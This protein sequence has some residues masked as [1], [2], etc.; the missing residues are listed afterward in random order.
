[1]TKLNPQQ[2]LIEELNKVSNNK[3]LIDLAVTLI[4]SNQDFINYN[5]GFVDV[6][7]N[8]KN[9]SIVEFDT[10]SN[11]NF[12]DLLSAIA[13]ANADK[14]TIT[15]ACQY[16]DLTVDCVRYLYS[17]SINVYYK[18]KI[19]RIK[20]SYGLT[21]DSYKRYQE[22]FFSYL[23]FT[24]RAWDSDDIKGLVVYG[25]RPSTAINCE[26]FATEVA[27][28]DRYPTALILT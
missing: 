28:L 15:N 2:I 17:K 25:I 21:R 7:F 5:Y 24:A 3:E 27:L 6:V 9:K 20:K 14:L 26:I 4:E 10:D 18:I 19:F 13:A 8:A 22:F 1:M 12:H 16:P 23:T 11:D